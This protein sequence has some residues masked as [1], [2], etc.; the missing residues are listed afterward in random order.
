[1]QLSNTTKFL[2][3]G[4]VFLVIVILVRNSGEP[5]QNDG[6]LTYEQDAKE[7]AGLVDENK[8]DIQ[9]LPLDLDSENSSNMMDH[10][11]RLRNKFNNKNMATGG[12][13]HSS[14][15]E[16]DRREKSADFDQFF[17]SNNE[18]VSGSYKENDG[19]SGRDESNGQLAGYRPGKKQQL[20]DE[21]IFRA[22][23]YLPQEGNKDWFEVM[24]EPISVKNRHLINVTRP[25]GVNTI[26]SSLKNASYDLRGTPVTPK[27][28]IS[29]FLNSS[30]EPDI[31]NKGLC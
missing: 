16:G 1:M 4:A 20:S 31:S 9:N 19:F 18:L 25:V 11:P 15:A 7:R 14:Y 21:D 5:F 26:G 13:K 30:I 3:V 6:V 27:F 24:P 2:L 17:E 23:D 22:D 8:V 10:E 28:V 12:Y 29:P